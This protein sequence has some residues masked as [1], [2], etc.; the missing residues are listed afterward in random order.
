MSV[1]AGE[2]TY[3]ILGDVDLHGL[4]VETE[5]SREFTHAI[6]PVVEE[7]DSVAIW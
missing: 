4:V 3:E 6:R 2:A 7:K 1:G 5:D